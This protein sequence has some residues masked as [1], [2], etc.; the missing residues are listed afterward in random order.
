VGHF[1]YSLNFTNIVMCTWDCTDILSGARSLTGKFAR[2]KPVKTKPDT[3]VCPPK[4]VTGS[5][6][7]WETI[8]NPGK[9]KRNNAAAG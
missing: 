9:V 1:L 6:L 7:G 4:T 3:V 8:R 2:L 5:I